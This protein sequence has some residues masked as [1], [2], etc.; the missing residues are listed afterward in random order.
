MN[1]LEKYGL[2]GE[3]L[4]HS[5]SEIIH[6]MLGNDEY[7]LLPMTKEEFYD[8]F[9]RHPFCA[10][11]VTIPYKTD[12]YRLCNVLSDEARSIG[13]VNTVVNKNGTLYGDN[14][15]IFGFIYMLNSA[16]IDVRNK[17]V[18]ILGTGGT[19][20]TANAACRMLGAKELITVS[21]KG[22]VNY[23]NVYTNH[24]DVQI[25]I[26]TTPVGMYPSNG[27]SPIDI[28]R[29]CN[30]C[31]VA[32]VI[33]NPSKTRLLID[34]QKRGI[35]T[36]GGLCMLVAQAVEA[37]RIFFDKKDVDVDKTVKRILEKIASGVHNII[38]VGMPG[39]GKTTV[40]RILSQKLCREFIDADEY[41]TQKEGRTPEDIITN[42]G[43]AAFRELETKTLE[44]ITKLSGK[45]ISCGGGAVI[46]E[47][48]RELINQNSICIYIM[49]DTDKLATAGR[50]LSKGGTERLKELFEKRDPL[51]NMCADFCV[52]LC[53]D[54]EECAKKI[55]ERYGFEK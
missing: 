20:L 16:G 52:N 7:R 34:A 38:L 26:N 2:C 11:N 10:V 4:S 21:R 42:D 30:L 17:K 1:E 45:V 47:Y 49:R 28:S 22:N 27:A 44:E 50:P 23:E 13:S 14:T 5:Y 18:L 40:G 8:F 15:D 41:L 29:F 36:A 19:S 33:Y 37:D 6:K 25:I 48:N 35:K 3:K 51:Y 9:A 46:S 24:S 55:I 32:D 31:G 54:G 12:A 39:C 53:E 43:E